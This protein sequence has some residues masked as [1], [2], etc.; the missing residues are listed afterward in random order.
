MRGALFKGRS[1]VYAEAW[2]LGERIDAR[3]LAGCDVL[4]LSPLTLRIGEDGIAVVFRFGA[5]VVFGDGDA[6]EILTGIRP[7]VHAAFDEPESEGL[8]IHLGA[9]AQERVGADGVL[10]LHALD[11]G[12]AHVVADVLAK[13]VVLAH[14]EETVS[15]VVERVEQMAEDLEQLRSPRAAKLVAAEMGRVLRAQLRTVGRVGVT[16]QPELTW[17]APELERLHRVLSE[18]YDLLERDGLLSRKLDLLGRTG[19]IALDLLHNRRSHRLELYIVWLIVVEVVLIVY[20][21]AA[22]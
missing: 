4:S 3:P 15:P 6:S 9:D 17:E 20:D 18:Q 5:V 11:L 8:E 21:I 2:L 10:Q 7:R 13:S 22:H 16:E 14:Y 19:E 12:V 1:S